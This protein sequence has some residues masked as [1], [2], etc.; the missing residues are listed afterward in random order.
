MSKKT[1]FIII[2]IIIISGISLYAIFVNKPTSTQPKN[3]NQSSL[4]SPENQQVANCINEKYGY[5]LTYPDNWKVWVRGEGEARSASCDENL[6]RYVFT[7][8]IPDLKNQINFTVFTRGSQTAEFWE[9]KESID[10]YVKRLSSWSIERET[11]L[12]GERLIW[13]RSKKQSQQLVAYHNDSIYNFRIY[14]VADET[15]NKF[16]A[17]FKFKK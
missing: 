17:S 10:D 12:D 16:I 15:L 14:D 9:D 3:T 4:S 6:S 7:E 5:E 13:L 8:G 11:L 2:G 1:L